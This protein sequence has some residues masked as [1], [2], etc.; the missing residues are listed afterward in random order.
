[1]DFAPAVVEKLRERAAR[2]DELTT[3]L[4][5][6]EVASD[7][8]RLAEIARERGR[9][10]R[11]AELAAKLEEWLSRNEEA[12]SILEDEDGDAEMADL[13]REELAELEGAFEAFDELIKGELVTDEDDHRDKVIVEVRAGAGGDEASLFVVDLLRMYTRFAESRKWRLELL[14]SSAT[15][16]GGMKEVSFAL[17]GE[18]TWRLMQ[19]ESGGHRVQRVP[20]TETQGRIHT[21]A[22]TVAVMPEAEDVDVDVKDADLRIDTMRSSGPGGQ[23]VNKTSS[24]VRITHLPTNT[25]VIC[26]DEKSQHKNKAQAMRILRARLFEAERRRRHEERA[27]LRRDQIGSGDR[28]DRVRTYN[29]PQNRVSDHRL[30]ENF[31]LEKVVAGHLGPIVEA[32]DRRDREERILAL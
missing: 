19:F 11:S 31:S 16:V 2:F 25:V 15:E 13:A 32:L 9:L 22:A 17:R 12:R 29:W 5:T 14:D 18:G 20:V 28:S 10:E 6:P 4:S 8:K 27:A 7:G 1:M 23:S 21:S 3:L 30:G 24:A 26:Q